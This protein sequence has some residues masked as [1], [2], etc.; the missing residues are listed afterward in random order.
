MLTEAQIA[1]KGCPRRKHTFS[2]ANLTQGR[3]PVS[4]E[5]ISIAQRSREKEA[6]AGA[7]RLID[8]RVPPLACPAVFPA[9]LDKPAVAPIHQAMGALPQLV[10]RTRA[11]FSG[12]PRRPQEIRPRGATRA[13]GGRTVGPRRSRPRS[14]RPARSLCG[15]SSENHPPA[16]DADA[17]RPVRPRACR[18]R[19]G[20]RPG[21]SPTRSSAPG[22]RAVRRA[23]LAHRSPRRCSAVNRSAGLPRIPAGCR[24]E[25]PTPEGNAGPVRRPPR[26]WRPSSRHR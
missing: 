6:V 10:L 11:R 16:P 17:P 1:D 2:A 8:Q 15:G 5:V 12:D 22:P 26:W 3:R 24:G 9:L 23:R 25:R 14:H 4:A 18:P 7:L 21:A 13:N 19:P 20:R